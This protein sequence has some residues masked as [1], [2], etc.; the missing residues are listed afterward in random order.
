ME[1]LGDAA[2][3]RLR[4]IQYKT[5]L[6]AQR[7]NPE[8]T[9]EQYV[10]FTDEPPNPHVPIV[11]LAHVSLL[12]RHALDRDQAAAATGEKIPGVG[13]SVERAAARHHGHPD[14]TKGEWLARL[15]RSEQKEVAERLHRLATEKRDVG[16]NDEALELYCWALAIKEVA[17]GEGSADESL[18]VTLKGLAEMQ[19]ELGEREDAVA[20]YAQALAIEEKVYGGTNAVVVETIC[21]MGDAVLALGLSD[22]AMSLYTEARIK[23]ED[24]YGI[25]HSAVATALIGIAGIHQRQQRREESLELYRRAVE[26]KGQNHG[27]SSVEL[28]AAM[29][30]LGRA[31]RSVGRNSEA[32]ST[33]E[34]ALEIFQ[35]EHG[36]DHVDVVH[37]ADDVGG[38]LQNLAGVHRACGRDQEALECLQEALPLRE[39]ALGSASPTLAQ[40][41]QAS[42]S[43]TLLWY[44]YLNQSCSLQM[45]CTLASAYALLAKLDVALILYER[46]LVI[47]KEAYG[48]DSKQ[49]RDTTKQ[50]VEMQKILWV[51]AHPD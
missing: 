44:R 50:M 13:G 12:D 46:A 10:G 35:L 41:R 20:L 40:V 34:Q 36:P 25:D 51:A 3:I 24:A 2:E 15:Q 27:P 29:R 39:R 28:A 18:A 23:C 9:D 43:F 45:L 14:D 21:A 16:E 19:A 8:P 5:E 4:V 30:G 31:L 38:V 49:V 42:I 11:V 37:T 22:A 6:W 7:Y 32:L 26:I 48:A 33:L 1:R 47:R 17:Y